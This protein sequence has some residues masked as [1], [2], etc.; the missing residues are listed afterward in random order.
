[1]LVRCHRTLGTE[2]PA[3]VLRRLAPSATWR[4]LVAAAERTDPFE[5]VGTGRGPSRLL[6]RACRAS[7]RASA[8]ELVRRSVRATRPQP[9]GHLGPPLDPDDPRSGLFQVGGPQERAHFLAE[10]AR[11]EV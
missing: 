5:R 9:F 11:G 2:V 4:A 1:M 7:T 3:D 6:A 8:L 10:V